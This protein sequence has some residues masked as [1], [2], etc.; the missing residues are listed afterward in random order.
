M[1]SLIENGDVFFCSLKLHASFDA[2]S[3]NL[4]MKKDR[5][6]GGRGAHCMLTEFGLMCHQVVPRMILDIR[7]MQL[8]HL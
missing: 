7:D 3:W 8:D 2:L 5:G 4:V 1:K 6:K